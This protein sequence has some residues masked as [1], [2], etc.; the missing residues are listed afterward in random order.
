MTITTAVVRAGASATATT[1]DFTSSGFG[2]AK[3]CIVICTLAVTDGTA[4][5]DN[6]FGLGFA[7][8]TSNRFCQCPADEDGVATQDCTR[9]IRNDSIIWLS[10]P[11]SSGSLAVAD[12]T[13]FITDGIRITWSSVTG[14]QELVTVIL[15]GGDDLSAHA[16]SITWL[17]TVNEAIDVTAPG[18]EPDIVFMIGS[19]DEV[20]NTPG[21]GDTEA[22]FGICHND[23]ASGITQRA[24]GMRYDNGEATSAVE[25]EFSTDA[26]LVYSNNGS[27]DW[28]VELGTFDSSGFTATARDAGGNNSVCAYLALKFASHSSWVG[29]HSTPTSTGNSADTGP[30]FTPQFAMLGPSTAITAD[31]L[32]TDSTALTTG[33]AAFDGTNEFCTTVSSED[34]QATMDTQSLS[35]NTAV[36]V[37]DSGGTALLTASYVSFDANGFTL[38]YSAVDASN[39]RLFWGFA[40]EED[41]AAGGF[42]WPSFQRHPKTNLLLRL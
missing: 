31:T 5:A 19:R 23:G 7:T 25:M 2:T 12:F 14:N 6:A 40:V 28:E 33:I 9:V 24:I 18:F 29:T 10:N 4:A 26:T 20:F 41:A 1:Q 38:N 39:I 13:A 36:N 11:G 34:G 21:G 42:P 30:G 16:N 3:A 35:D 15:L 37:P 8:G 22:S 32:Y 17:D 27:H